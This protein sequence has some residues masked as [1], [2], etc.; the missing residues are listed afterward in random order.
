MDLLPAP[1]EVAAMAHPGTASMLAIIESPRLVECPAATM[2]VAIHGS[3]GELLRMLSAVR[4]HVQLNPHARATPR[5][6][7]GGVMYLGHNLKFHDPEYSSRVVPA[8]AEATRP[9]YWVRSSDPESRDPTAGYDEAT[10]AIAALG[11]AGTHASLEVLR[12]MIRSATPET[13]YPSGLIRIQVLD[14]AECG[15]RQIRNRKP[16]TLPFERRTE[17]LP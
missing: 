7:V 13:A 14:A 2:V 15:E 12:S 17:S 10:A 6:I 16:G 11:F 4:R 8:I 9:E 5:I 1:A 3:T